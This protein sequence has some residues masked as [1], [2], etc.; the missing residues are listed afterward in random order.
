VNIAI[1]VFMLAAMV[2]TL[3][4][5]LFTNAKIWRFVRES[6][7]S[8]RALPAARRRNILIRMAATYAFALAEAI[9]VI[10]AP[11]GVRRTLTYFVILPVVVLALAVVIIAGVAG[12]R[13]Q[14][15][16]QPPSRP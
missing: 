12:A 3:G 7:A 10:T 8:I 14:R 5:T 13:G 11:F 1:G 9:V 16:R 4:A 6:H 15:R 2:I